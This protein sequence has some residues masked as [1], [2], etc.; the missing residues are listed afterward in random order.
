M[1]YGAWSLQNAP[2][3]AHITIENLNGAF[4]RLHAPYLITER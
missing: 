1:K 2:T 3:F 4:R